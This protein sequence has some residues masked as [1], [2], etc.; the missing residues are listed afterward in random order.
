MNMQKT[1]MILVLEFLKFIGAL[2]GKRN[3]IRL[4]MAFQLETEELKKEISTPKLA[5]I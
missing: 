1:K 5:K 2:L 3:D 4:V